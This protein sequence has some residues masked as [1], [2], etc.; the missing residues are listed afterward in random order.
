[1]TQCPCGMQLEYEECCERLHSGKQ[2]AKTAEEL[3]RSRY[4]AFARNQIG[5]LRDTTWP[6]YRKH[7]DEIAYTDRAVGSIW[8]GLTIHAT[9]EGQEGDTTGSV[10]FTARS[11]A[12]GQLSEQIEHSLFRKRNNKWYYVKPLET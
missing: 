9:E 2:L 8:M 7:F 11:M 5:Y 12:H 10:K 4:S 3:M 1:M 6:A